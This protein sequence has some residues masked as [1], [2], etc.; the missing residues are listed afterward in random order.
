LLAEEKRY[1]K[2]NER[3]YNK[4]R[5]GYIGD[6]TAIQYAQ[7]YVPWNIQLMQEQKKKIYQEMEEARAKVESSKT[8]S[9]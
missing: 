5:S 8:A 9:G 1:K 7:D 6:T 2:L 3:G 4:N